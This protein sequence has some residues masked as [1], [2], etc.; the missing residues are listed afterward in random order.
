MS[1]SNNSWDSNKENIVPYSITKLINA[2]VYS[3]NK[4]H[5]RFL[6][7]NLNSNIKCYLKIKI[8]VLYYYNVCN[9]LAI[10]FF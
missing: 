2:K 4:R 3:V 6:L 10:V 9:Y 1:Y 5:L 8:I 7:A